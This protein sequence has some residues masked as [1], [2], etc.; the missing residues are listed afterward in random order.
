MTEEQKPE[1]PIRINKYLAHEGR[2]SRREIDRLVEEGK[3]LI[4][5]KV[6]ELG[7]KVHEGDKIEIATR[8]SREKEQGRMRALERRNRR[9]KG[10]R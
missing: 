10:R 1:F 9:D 5:G 7:A 6:A 8:G 2:G 3:V 4:N